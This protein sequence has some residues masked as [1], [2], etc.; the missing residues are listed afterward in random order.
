V[1]SPK[2]TL[3]AILLGGLV[4]AQ[5]VF[6]SGTISG[7]RA[8]NIGSAAM[9]GRISA[10]DCRRLPDQ[11][12]T[13]FVGSAS[14]GV[15]RSRDGGTTFKPV[16]D[17]QPV[18]SIGAITID[19]KDP[20]VVWVGSGESWTRNSV[21][22]GNGIYRTSD[23]GETWQHL[24]LAGSERIAKIVVDPRDSQVVY[25]CV[26]GP[27]W[28]DSSE[29]GL[30]QTID[31]GKSWKKIL[32]G[33]NLSTGCASLTIDPKNPEVMLAG[34]W[35]FRRQGWTFRSGGPTPS[36]ASGS[37]LWRSSDGGQNWSPVQGQGLP[38]GPWGRVE[39]EIAPSNPDRVYAFIECAQ[40]ALYVS[41]DG[42]RNWQKRDSSRNMVWRPF[43]FANLIVDPKNADRLFKTNLS[44]IV[45]ED[46]GKSF[47]DVSG[48]SH[49][50][51]HDVWID[52]DNPKHVIGGDDGGLWIS[53][54]GGNRWWKTD[55]LPI[56]Q[57][58][59]VS[60]DER[61]PYQ[62]YGGLQDNSSWVG[63]SAYPGGITNSRWENLYG[64]DGFWVFADP[65]DPHF[66]YAEY[67]GGG[68]SR[69][70]R[71]TLSARDIQ[72]RARAGEKL[73]Y[74]WNTPLHLSPNRK[75]SIY[76]GSQFLFR[77]DDHGE[78]WQRLSPDLTSNNPAR[79]KQ[80]ESGGI[81]VDNSA[82]ET[83]CTIYSISESPRNGKLIW[84]GTDDGLVQVTR[85]GGKS[86]TKVTPPMPQAEGGWV[87][88]VEASPHREGTAFVTIDRHTFGDMQPYLWRTDDFGKSW[89]PLT[90]N[91]QGYLH[92]VK[93]DPLRPDLL[94]VGSELGLWISPDS[95]AHWAA[96]K[97]G[98]FPSVAVRDLAIHPR[99]HDLVIATHGRGIWILDDLT[100]LRHLGPK[101][102]AQE[103]CLVPSR[104]TQQ[105]MPAGGGWVEGDAKFIGENPPGGAVI[106]FYQQKRHIYGPL[107]LEIFDAQGKL[108][109]TL[110]VPK[111]RGLSRI[112]WSMRH[113]PPQVPKAATVAG[114][115]LNGP[116]VLPGVYRLRITKGDQVYE[117]PLQIGLDRRA[118]FGLEERKL[119]L[120]ACQRVGALFGRMSLVVD[121]IRQ[122]E[123]QCQQRKD[124]G[125]TVLELQALRKKLVATTEGGAITGEERLREKL[126]SLY[127]SL[128][129]YEGRPAAY[130][131]EALKVLEEDFGS[132]EKE[133]QALLEKT[134]QRLQQQGQQLIEIRAEG[135]AEPAA[136]RLLDQVVRDTLPES[137]SRPASLRRSRKAR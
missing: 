1:N 100:P 3:L 85:D 126:D 64:G 79:Q 57:F 21:S 19:P 10:L 77:S 123:Q 58:Y 56:S 55:N 9:S 13:L 102:L 51:W 104:P 81:T 78:S 117:A 87:S 7:V 60:V 111:R 114:S 113:K 16:F 17:K 38:A 44:L 116:R 89:R 40:S 133:W 70:D 50:D 43:Y 120:A 6:D 41:D 71:R 18:Q 96:F 67:Q 33:P 52:P 108:L 47:S 31:G 65:S 105:R 69:I 115:S 62:V 119:Q 28:G 134:N 2:S 42:G 12:L 36:S 68:L 121:Q 137:V 73:R 61:D 103:A 94:Y 92:V 130:L 49:C 63:D 83:H 132:V 66:V 118:G 99:E 135:A 90:G 4:W 8:R 136:A 98:N 93:E 95:G 80:E 86:W 125:E 88:W 59:H 82:A 91:I 5:P 122:L 45:S 23:G 106:H 35:D 129:G 27:L 37:G 46:G 48:G 15:W 107:K 124:C 112:Q 34:M 26:P 101:E 39:V 20:K 32:A 97:G 29:R 11:T 110:P 72:P 30:Y 74:N 84:V 128:N 109:D 76:I 131:L 25:V 53:H 24:G 54:D 75:G 14:G 127:S 22:I